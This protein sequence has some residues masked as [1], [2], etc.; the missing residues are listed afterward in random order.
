LIAELPCQ[1]PERHANR[2]Y[3]GAAYWT[4]GNCNLITDAIRTF[5]SQIG[6]LAALTVGKFFGPLKLVVRA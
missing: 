6:L 2:L 3:K 1:R 5:A 4:L